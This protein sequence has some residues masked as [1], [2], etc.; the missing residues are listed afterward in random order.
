MI[1]AIL[2]STTDLN[3]NVINPCI[4]FISAFSIL[5][6]AFFSSRKIGKKGILIGF[7]QG[8]IYMTILY[9]F[10]SISSGNFSLNISSLIMILISLICGIIGGILGVNILK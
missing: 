2:L 5:I 1:L 7:L 8:L 10:S 4:I 3:E 9:L 6:G